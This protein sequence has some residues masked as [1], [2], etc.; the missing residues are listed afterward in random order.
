[1]KGTLLQ[2]LPELLIM[3]NGKK[4]STRD[5]WKIRREEIKKMVLETGYGG[6]PPEPESTEGTLLCDDYTSKLKTYLVTARSGGKELS[7]EMRIYAPP[8]EKG[9]KYPVVIDGDGCWPY[10]TEKVINYFKRHEII[11]AQFNRCAVVRDVDDNQEVLNSPLY[12]LFPGISSGSLAGWAWAYSRCIDVLEKL[13][14]IDAEN[15]AITGHSRGGK[16]ALVAGAADERPR[17]VNSNCSGCGGCGCWRY[18]LGDITG[19]YNARSE[20]LADLLKAAPNWFGPQM[21]NYRDREAELPFDQHFLKALV[22]PRYLLQ[23][24]ASGDIWA[25]PPGSHG[26]LLAAGEAYRLLDAENNILGYYRKGP[27]AHTFEDYKRL[28]GLIS[29]ARNGT[30]PPRPPRDPYPEARDIF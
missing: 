26:T 16:A 23:T 9:K 1:M 4:V 20:V 24:D 3:E 25:N 28:A 5:E 2:K 19:A 7:F 17:I 14:Y 29:H 22:A 10:L 12:H 15:I 11:I 13:P 8:L 18:I 30:S 6:M 21:K 27:H